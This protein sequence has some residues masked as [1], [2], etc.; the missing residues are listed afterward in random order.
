MFSNVSSETMSEFL[1]VFDKEDLS[2]GS[3]QQLSK[4]LS[5]KVEEEENLPNKN[6][7]K[8][9]VQTGLIFVASGQNDFNGILKHLL[10]Q[11]NG[12]IEKEVRTLFLK[13]MI[14]RSRMER[15]LFTHSK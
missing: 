11:S 8:K 2:C 10:T 5:K 6:R 4:R 7:Y 14:V 15:I 13:R 12:Q 9:K 3:W 1:S